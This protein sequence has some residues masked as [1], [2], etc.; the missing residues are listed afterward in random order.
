MIFQENTDETVKKLG[1][2][3]QESEEK[4]KK[5]ELD[6]DTMKDQAKNLQAEY[7][8]VCELLKAAEVNIL[9]HRQKF[10][11]PHILK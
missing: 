2:Q 7:D 11:F 4:L 6:R 3:L 10:R 8:R 5:A 9:R 1:I